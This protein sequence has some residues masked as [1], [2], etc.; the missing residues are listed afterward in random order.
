MVRAPMEGM[1][2]NTACILVFEETG[3][4][5]LCVRLPSSY[6]HSHDRLPPPPPPQ[7]PPQISITSTYSVLDL[8]EDLKTMYGKAG[9]KDEG[10]LFLF[11]DSQIVNERF[12]VSINDLLA[13]GNIPDLFGVEEK[14]ALITAVTGKVKAAGLPLDKATC[15]NFFLSQVRPSRIIA[16]VPKCVCVVCVCERER[17]GVCALFAVCMVARRK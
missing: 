9:A 6:S 5:R 4:Q 14:D 12:L 8:R 15:W 1:C 2:L 10:T 16:M 13:S 11:T 7:P 17:G 3:I